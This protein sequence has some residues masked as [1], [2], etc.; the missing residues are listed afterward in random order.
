[1][2]PPKQGSCPYRSGATGRIS[3]LSYGVVSTLENVSNTIVGTVLQYWRI[4]VRWV[5]E[6]WLKWLRSSGDSN[7]LL[8]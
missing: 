6:P 3:H 1:M 8:E 7:G 5:N 4:V 2:L